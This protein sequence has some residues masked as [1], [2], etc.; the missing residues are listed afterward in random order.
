MSVGRSVCLSVGTQQ[1]P[2]IFF[3]LVEHTEMKYGIQIYHKNIL[4]K[5]CFGYN[6][7]IFDRVI[8]MPLGVRQIPIICCF[9]SFSLQKL[10]IL[11]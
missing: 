9:R 8:L 5:F 2:L 6:R 7:A 1:V 11:K 3:A 10:H 4:V